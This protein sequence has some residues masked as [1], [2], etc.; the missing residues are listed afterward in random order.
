MTLQV[1]L[2]GVAV[3]TKDLQPHV[4]HLF[5]GLTGIELEDGGVPGAGHIPVQSRGVAIHQHLG[6]LDHG[7]HVGQSVGHRLE[8]GD[9]LVELAALLGVRH[10]VGKGGSCGSGTGGR[11]T[12]TLVTKV[13]PEVGPPFVESPEQPGPGNPDIGEVEH[14]GSQ[15]PVAKG[16]DRAPFQPG[17]V[18]VDDEICDPVMLVAVRCGASRDYVEVA[19]LETGGEDLLP[20]E[21]VVVT[22]LDRRE[23]DRSGIRA[24][25][26][27]GQREAHGE[28]TGCDLGE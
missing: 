10:G 23:S 15:R 16:L 21:H 28:I 2:H 13:D 25:I 19:D 20:V 3:T 24:G 17:T 5:V 6:D 7:L 12:E 9:G 1:V 14:C 26:G 27:L 22:I 4:R 11:E 18:G 8:L